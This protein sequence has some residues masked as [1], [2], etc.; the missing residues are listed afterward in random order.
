MIILNDAGISNE[1]AR[2]TRSVNGRKLELFTGQL[3]NRA[4]DVAHDHPPKQAPKIPLLEAKLK[5]VHSA[6]QCLT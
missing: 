3:L 2:R 4:P 6:D 5:C 1:G